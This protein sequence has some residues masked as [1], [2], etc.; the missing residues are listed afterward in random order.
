LI[1]C[2][3]DAAQSQYS[4]VPYLRSPHE[5]QFGIVT[6]DASKSRQQP[7]SLNSQSHRQLDLE[8]IEPAPAEA[9]IVVP[10]EW[11]SLMEMNRILD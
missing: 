11:Q 2:Y 3:T 1:W 8:G 4:K 9:A 5:T 7:C 10:D 6:A